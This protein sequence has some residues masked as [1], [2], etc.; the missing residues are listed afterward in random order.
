MA[1]LGTQVNQ[2]I[3]FHLERTWGIQREQ[4]PNSPEKLLEG[5]KMMFGLGSKVVE[6]G[7]LREVRNS[8]GITPAVTDLR[9]AIEL[10]KETS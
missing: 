6:G 10:A 9:E 8:F 2:V 7:I 5:L 4:L 1:T 3:Y